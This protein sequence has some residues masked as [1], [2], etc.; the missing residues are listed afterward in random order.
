MTW[1]LKLTNESFITTTYSGTA[2]VIN[3]RDADRISCAVQ[4]P[5]LLIFCVCYLLGRRAIFYSEYLFFV[6]LSRPDV[7][8]SGESENIPR[9]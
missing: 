7:Q 1:W 6:A 3:P 8:T 9:W 4:S 5:F 2:F